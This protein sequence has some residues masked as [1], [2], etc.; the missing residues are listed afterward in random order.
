MQRDAVADR[1]PPRHRSDLRV[2]VLLQHLARKTV[3]T[4]R[5]LKF[6]RRGAEI[7]E[8]DLSANK[9]LR[10]ILIAT[11]NYS[12]QRFSFVISLAPIT[13]SGIFE[14]GGTTRVRVAPALTGRRPRSRERFQFLDSRLQRCSRPRDL[15]GNVLL[16]S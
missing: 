13:V 14:R 9:L 4:E 3:G 16:D 8:Q 2:S 1:E 12:S 15:L 5:G 10:E 6:F 7:D 11:Y